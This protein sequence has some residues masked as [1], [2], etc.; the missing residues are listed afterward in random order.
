MKDPRYSTLK[1]LLKAGAIK[2]FTDIFAWIPP[3]VV[4]NDFGT[5]NA[6]M[7]KM[8]DDPSLWTLAEIYQLAEWIGY[9][10]K[11][12]ALM[13]VDQVELMKKQS[14]DRDQSGEA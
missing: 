8:K 12:L 9:D 13:A 5:N 2:Q 6:R 11:K 10:K 3:T 14:P 1:G 4:A 7:K